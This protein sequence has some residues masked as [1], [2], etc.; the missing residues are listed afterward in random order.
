MRD[1]EYMLHIGEMS[2]TRSR[3]RIRIRFCMTSIVPPIFGL[4]LYRRRK[5][6][7]WD[8]YIRLGPVTKRIGAPP[9]LVLAVKN[10]VIQ[11]YTDVES[12]LVSHILDHSPPQTA[13]LP[14]N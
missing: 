11:D 12:C 6:Q 7:I 13:H 8:L 3:S 9:R 14:E 1:T 10:G 2:I 5:Y 4:I